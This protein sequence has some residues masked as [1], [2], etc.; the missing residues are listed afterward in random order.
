M[1]VFHG[2][3]GNDQKDTGYTKLFGEG[4][5]DLLGS[6]QPGQ[7]DIIGGSGWDYLFISVDVTAVGNLKGGSGHD[8]IVGY[9][10]T[11]EM[12]GGGGDDLI[13]GGAFQFLP[14]TNHPVAPTRTSG[15][16]H[17]N[18]GSGHDALYGFDGDDIINGDGGSDSGKIS[19][20]GFNYWADGSTYKLRAGLFGGDGH[21]TLDGG[22]GRDFLDGGP[23]S[24]LLT[25][26]AGADTFAFKSATDST[27]DTLRDVIQDF[28]EAD[29]DIV[30]LS[31]IDAKTGKSG[32]QAFH[33]IGGAEFSHVEG[34]LRFASGIL[35]G[36]RNGDGIADFQVALTGVTSLKEGDFVL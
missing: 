31:R 14:H 34:E 15:I 26:G 23:G 28:S 35:S 16:D 5:D 27:P 7:I 18:G 21:D 13:A 17:I 30:D 1:K 2:T 19:V 25:G 29:L 11:D 8:T 36:D 22:K 32:N 3:G 6:D 9:Q 20:P 12:T 10:L 24:D 4:G 33:F